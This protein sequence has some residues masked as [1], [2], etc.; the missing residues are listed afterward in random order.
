MNLYIPENLDLTEFETP[1][2]KKYKFKLDKAYYITHLLNA[3]PLWNDKCGSNDFVPLNAKTLKQKI[4][5]Y[6]EYLNWFIDNDIIESDNQYIVGEKSI[7]YRFT[8]KYFTKVREY[9][10]RD[11]TLKRTLIQ[12]KKNRTKTVKNLNYLNKWFNGLEINKD[13][14]YQYIEKRY[15]DKIDNI[16]K[17]DKDFKTGKLKNPVNQYNSGKMTIEFIVNNEH[18]I[19][20]DSNVYRYH[21]TL[22]TMQSPL[23]NSLTFKGQELINID[24]ANSQPYLA[25]TTLTHNQYIYN[26]IINSNIDNNIKDSYIMMCESGINSMISMDIKYQELTSEGMLYEYLGNNFNLGYKD[27]DDKKKQIKSSIFQV[28]FTDN[29]F[30]YQKDAEMKMKFKNLFP[31]EYEVFKLIKI[32]NKAYLPILLQNI[33]SHIVIDVVAKEIALKHPEIPLFTIH[34]SIATT[35][36]NVGIVKEIFDEQLTNIVGI[37]P[38]LRE[39]HWDI[40]NLL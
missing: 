21:S 3:I 25:N 15:D 5:N 34:D 31:R 8:K 2:F 13:I 11:F 23:R 7:G 4:D 9:Q 12:N 16:E 6:T 20:R 18:N 40:N 22:T 14:A 26:Y 29:R 19:K 24:I 10:I 32:K 33:E 35:L 17:W 36:D 39:E 1:K 30:L 38:T 27:E 28:L 37:K